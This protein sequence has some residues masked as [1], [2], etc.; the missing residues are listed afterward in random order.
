M[1]PNTCWL[2]DWLLPMTTAVQWSWPLTAQWPMTAA[3]ARRLCCVRCLRTCLLMGWQA[4]RHTLRHASWLMPW[5]RQLGIYAP[6]SS[7]IAMA[8]RWLLHV[9]LLHCA[10]IV[11]WRVICCLLQVVG[12]VADCLIAGAAVLS[13]RQC[14]SHLLAALLMYSLLQRWSIDS[15]IN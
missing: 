2:I 5:W 7:C 11:F 15:T 1:L 3:H 6:A 4:A 9:C 12:C 8:L 14:C 13:C 10:V